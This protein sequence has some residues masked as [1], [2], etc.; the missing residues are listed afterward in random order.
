MTKQPR[1]TLVVF[2]IDGVLFDPHPDRV[3]AYL[4]GRHDTYF[5]MA[6]MDTPIQQ[7]I[8]MCRMF[9]SAGYNVLFVTGRGDTP[10][11]RQDTLDMLQHHLGYVLT[12]DQL[13]MRKFPIPE[14]EAHEDHVVKPQ[15]IERAGY[16][17]NDIFL[18]FEDRPSIVNMWRERGITCY[19]TQEGW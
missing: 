4:D 1:K 13:L 9:L 7:G 10:T 17:L 16:F 3:Q 12:D 8:M 19:Q 6:W 11:H 15:M 2:D 18:V 5:S 14:D